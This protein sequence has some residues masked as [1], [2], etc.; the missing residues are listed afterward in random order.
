MMW[1][2]CT[3]SPARNSWLNF[4]VRGQFEILI[5]RH[6]HNIFHMNFLKKNWTWAGITWKLVTCQRIP[7]KNTWPRKVDTWAGDT[8]MWYWSAGTLNWSKH[9]CPICAHYQFSW[10]PFLTFDS[11]PYPT[12]TICRRVRTYARSITWQPN[13]KRLTIFHEYGALSHAA[14]RARGCPAI[15]NSYY[16]YEHYR[17]NIA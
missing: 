1:I 9:G 13:E 17:T 4:R 5:M 8:V 11:L 2:M 14:L 6:K 3:V 10:H 7:S 16:F 12:R 15:N